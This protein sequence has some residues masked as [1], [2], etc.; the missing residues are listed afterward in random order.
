MRYVTPKYRTA[1]AISAM[2]VPAMLLS[3]AVAVAQEDS[4][5]RK[6]AD[7]SVRAST[8]EAKTPE[9][10]W[11][12]SHRMRFVAWDAGLWGETGA[13]VQFT[14]NR[15]RAGVT[16]HPF[17]SLTL[18]AAVVNEFFNWL[19]YPTPRD[20]NL[21]E[22][23]IEHLWLRFAATLGIPLE[24]TVG[25]QDLFLGEGF[26]IGDGTPLDGSRTIAMNAARLDAKL[27]LG[28]TVTAMYIHQPVRDTW[29]TPINDRE[30][31]L[32]EYPVTVAGLWYAASF[33]DLRGA[34]YALRSAVEDATNPRMG[35]TGD[36]EGN[37]LGGQLHL[38]LTPQ[39][40]VFGEYAWQRGDL[41][42][43]GRSYRSTRGAG[44]YVFLEWSDDVL[45]GTPMTVRLGAVEYSGSATGLERYREES[46]PENF[47][48]LLGRWPKWN[49]S[50]VFSQGILPAPGYWTN[51]SIPMLDV[52]VAPSSAWSVR[53]GAQLLRHD[54]KRYEKHGAK[55]IGELLLLHVFWKPQ[56]PLSALLH[57]ERLWYDPNY[58]PPRSGYWWGRVEVMYRLAG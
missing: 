29:L 33:Q 15:T 54:A 3:A 31:R 13:P 48:P 10:S 35:Y 1:L 32:Q 7:A 39:W 30:K 41:L 28:H 58:A 44:F 6:A 57:L 26:L 38:E 50:L 53:L 24:L 49:E 47:D 11:D 2:I 45:P 25:R 14:R 12:F 21:D 18:R 22:I 5:A 55:R 27:A 40:K 4:T 37:T 19:E 8:G 42:H 17:A 20:F 34:L 56:L 43:Y 46:D 16:W 23:A 9:W 51:L 52:I 36:S